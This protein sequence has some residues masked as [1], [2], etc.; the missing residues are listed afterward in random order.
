M[1]ESITIV[2]K[3]SQN[4]QCR[5]A[6]WSQLGLD[7]GQQVRACAADVCELLQIGHLGSH[8]KKAWELSRGHDP[9]YLAGKP[10]IHAVP[11]NLCKFSP[12]MHSK[13]FLDVTNGLATLFDVHLPV[14]E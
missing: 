3:L 7:R 13:L 6:R 1:G 9:G 14:V 10:I 2:S 11:S 4:F 5:R 8:I 12:G